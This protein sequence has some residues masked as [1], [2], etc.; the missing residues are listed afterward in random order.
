VTTTRP[1]QSALIPSLA[2]TPDQLTAANVVAG[3]LEAAGA[4]AAG[5]VV[6]VLISLA[7]VGSVFAVCA[8]LGLV[9]ALL[10]VG[11]RVTGLAGAEQ[12]TE[13]PA[14]G[15]VEGLRLALR[16]RRLRLILAL[17]TADAVVLGALDLLVVILALTVLGRPPG[18]A[19]YLEFA[20]GVGAVLAATVSAALVGR[21]LGGPILGA[22]LV[23][24]GAL[25]AVAFGPG[26]AG[27]VI[28]LAMAGAGHLLLEV[29]T[30]TLLQRSVPPRLIGRIFGVL[31]GFTMAGLAVG[32][33]LVPVLAHLGG[34]RLAVLGVAA[35]LPLAAVAGGRA[36]F[37]LDAGTAVPVVEIALLRSLPLFAELPAPAIEGLAAALRP[38]RLDAGAVLIRQGDPGDA[39]FAIAAGELDAE[40]DGRFL[41]RY[42]RGD[43]GSA[44]NLT[45]LLVAREAAGGPSPDSV[46]YVSDQ[47]HSS[48]ARTARAMGLRPHQVR[49]L[50]TDD[51]WHLLPETVTAAVRADRAA[52]RVPFALC[53]SAGS[54]NT[55]AVDPLAGL[56]DVCRAERLWL[57][58]DAA[59]GGFA[60][61]TAKGK[62]L[63]SGIERADSVTLDPH[64][65]LY[66]PM[67][68]G[69]VLIR[70]GARLERTFAIH[71]DYLDGDAVQGSGEVNFADRGL[72]LSR[73]FRALKV[74]VTLHTFGLEAF[75]ACIQRNLDLAEYAEGLI[76][77][78]PELTVMA[79]ATLGLVCFR[80]EWP[81]CDEAE[82]ERRGTA[83]AEELERGGTAL[84]STTRLAG[85]HAIRL[86]ILN[87][88]TTARHVR[89]VIEHFAGALAPVAG[90]PA[91]GAP[92]E[93]AHLGVPGPDVLGA[94][95]LL[96]GVPAS[97]RHAVQARGVCLD[98][99]AGEE[100]I[101]R[102]DADRFF[103]IVLTGRYDVF[104]DTRLIRTHGPGDHFGE[105]AA[106][107]W[108]GGYGYARLATV[109]CAEPGRLLKLTTEDLAWLVDSQPTVKARIAAT[110]A[111]RLQ[112]R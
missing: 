30:R 47:A 71:P 73:G 89:Q 37:R 51:G 38:V 110:L 48:L 105:L 109:R 43:G 61:L 100:V 14:E 40:Q 55:G 9:A 64:K 3:W 101:R 59:Y 87:P 20:F 10:V 16:Q 31:E 50:P 90:A 95:P 111:E 108:G 7:G 35:V 60:A 56:A 33:L 103:Y 102:W 62:T 11:L 67:E 77:D 42:G 80:R 94:V 88:T 96:D 36:V 107:D 5:L 29:A 17:L 4:A 54:T 22:A 15:A 78:C 19:G 58:V 84:V 44:A 45:A 86:C 1:A 69:C 112:H 27:T 2:V 25:A 70:D 83:L 8:G 97:T 72:Q 32:A 18:W 104:I 99:A 21:R 52:G 68:C 24:S 81:G 82:T 92:A 85:R 91:R 57:H 34:S 41:G 75:R 93:V 23:F 106:R 26:L 46:V 49:V 79:P 6:G 65:W 98:V 74:W 76:R 53:A 28:L 13:E 39:Y 66:Q 12:G 63:L